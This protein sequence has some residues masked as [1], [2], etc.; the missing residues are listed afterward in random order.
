MM[1]DKEAR[2]SPQPR[3]PQ[4]WVSDSDLWDCTTT[5]FPGPSL[6]CRGA[7]LAAKGSC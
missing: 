4:S 1:A 3:M 5:C 7:I 2:S 6:P